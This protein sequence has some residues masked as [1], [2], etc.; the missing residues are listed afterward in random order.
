M[1]ISVK[2]EI[3]PDEISRLQE[4]IATLERQLRRVKK[5]D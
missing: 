3:T 4:K 1:E 2:Q 5:E